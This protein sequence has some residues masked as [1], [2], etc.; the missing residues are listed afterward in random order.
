MFSPAVQAT[1]NIHQINSCSFKLSL[2]LFYCKL[3]IIASATYKNYWHALILRLPVL[4]GDLLN[5]LDDLRCCLAYT[6]ANDCE[7]DVYLWLRKQTF[8]ISLCY[9]CA[10]ARLLPHISSGDGTNREK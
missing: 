10:C 5:C 2:Q 7:R 9:I 1:F 6:F 8:K 3:R 4:R